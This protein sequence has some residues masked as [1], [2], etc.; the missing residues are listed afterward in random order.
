MI[1]DFTFSNKNKEIIVGIIATLSFFG[2]IAVVSGVYGVLY[3]GVAF[4]ITVASINLFTRKSVT[5]KVSAVVLNTDIMYK[6]LMPKK[7]K[8]AIKDL[9]AKKK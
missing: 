4:V 2:F 5:A 1:N 6:I 8:K 3:L 7:Y 9:E